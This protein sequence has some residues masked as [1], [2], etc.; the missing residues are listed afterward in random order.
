MNTTILMIVM[1]GCSKVDTEVL[2][3]GIETMEPNDCRE[4]SRDDE[5]ANNVLATT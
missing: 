4:M 3:I 2:D 5:D 1:L